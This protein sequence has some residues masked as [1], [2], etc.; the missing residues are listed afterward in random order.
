MLIENIFKTRIQQWVLKVNNGWCLNLYSE[1][2]DIQQQWS[3]CLSYSFNKKLN[4]AA[5][6]KCFKEFGAAVRMV[7]TVGA[8]IR[9]TRMLSESE[10]H[11]FNFAITMSNLKASYNTENR[12]CF[13]GAVKWDNI[14]TAAKRVSKA[15]ACLNDG[16]N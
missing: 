7:H 1:N 6:V 12:L 8:V 16:I 4:P 3:V 9:S 14:V 11:K 5:F 15:L 13:K 2:E 10:V